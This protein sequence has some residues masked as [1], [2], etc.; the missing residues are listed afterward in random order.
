MGVQKHLTTAQK[1]EIR[2]A[3]LG[4]QSPRNIFDL[5]DGI[6]W[7]N[8]VHGEDHDDQVATA[9]DLGLTIGNKSQGI[10]IFLADLE[11]EFFADVEDDEDEDDDEEGEE[12]ED[13]DDGDESEDD[14]DEPDI[15]DIT[16]EDD[17]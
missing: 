11:Q 4:D 17:D 5:V 8:N 2:K 6:L 14:E 13:D 12:D 7:T 1:N 10:E 15:D 9:R 16:V 3:W